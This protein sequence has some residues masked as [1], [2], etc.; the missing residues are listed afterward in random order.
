M[1][2]K[3]KPYYWWDPPKERAAFLAVF[4]DEDDLIAMEGPLLTDAEVIC[5]LCNA[6]VDVRPV[7]VW[8]AGSQY[9]LCPDCFRRVFKK[10][11]EDAAREDGVTLEHLPVYGGAP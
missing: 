5:D 10:T 7:P 1:S 4:A 3:Q 8:K 6:L 9:A 11:V 2:Q